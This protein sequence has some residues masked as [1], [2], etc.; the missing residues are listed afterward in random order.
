LEIGPEAL[1]SQSKKGFFERKGKL[2]DDLSGEEL[3][4]NYNMEENSKLDLER[5]EVSE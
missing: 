4:D 3:K 2:V 5:D 1:K